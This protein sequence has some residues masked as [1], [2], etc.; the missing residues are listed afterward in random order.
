MMGGVLVV[1]I[2]QRKGLVCTEIEDYTG[3]LV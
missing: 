1:S 3:R 2:D